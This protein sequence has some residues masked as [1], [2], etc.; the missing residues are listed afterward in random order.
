M[1][2][3]TKI[4]HPLLRSPGTSQRK[5][6]A[7]AQSL[8]PELAAVDGRKLGD[9]LDFVHRYARQVVFHQYKTNAEGQ[10]YVEL[11]N[12]LGFFEK[13]LP[14]TLNQF[15]RT[16]FNQLEADLQ[17]ILEGLEQKPDAASLRLLL[18]FCYFDLIMPFDHLQKAVRE[19]GFEQLMALLD[20]IVR[21]SLLPLLRHFIEISKTS[22]QY[23]RT[24][25]YDFLG[26]T[27]TPWDI[28]I[29]ELFEWS[30]AVLG[31]QDGV[32]MSLGCKLGEIM[33][34]WLVEQRGIADKLPGFLYPSISFL[35]QRHE[36]HLGLLYAFLRLFEHF[37]GNL[38]GLT[39]QH[40]EFFYNDV[41]RLK[42]RDM[43]P[44]QAHLVFE[45]SKHLTSHLIGEGTLFK[46]AKDGKNVDILFGLDEEIVIDKAKVVALKT[47]FL[48]SS[49][50]YTKNAAGE[51]TSQSVVE[52]VY[53]APVANSADGNGKPFQEKQSKNWP[54][55]GA[56]VSK[57]TPESQSEPANYPLGRLG[58][59]LASPVLWLNEGRR[60]VTITI[61]CNVSEYEK[62]FNSCSI[63]ELGEFE[64][65]T[66]YR[67]TGETIKSVED[68]FIEDRNVLQEEFANR[69][70]VEFFTEGEEEPS[71]NDFLN[72]ISPKNR[73]LLEALA[74]QDKKGVYILKEFPFSSLLQQLNLLK[75]KDLIGF[76]PADFF[77]TT[78]WTTGRSL[79][80]EVLDSNILGF[81]EKT[82]VFR[83]DIS[84]FLTLRFSG[85]K[86]WLSPNSQS[87]ALISKSKKPGGNVILRIGAILDAEKPKV[88]FYNEKELKETFRTQYPMVQIVL[89]QEPPL[90]CE[91]SSAK[92]VCC[93]EANDKPE[94]VSV[95]LYHFFRFLKVVK[96]TIDVK[97][98]GIK[99]LVVQNEESL[100]DVN[101]LIY[102]FGTRPKL[103][104]EF[105]VG[106]KELLCK[107]WKEFSLNVEW[108]EKPADFKKHY[109]NYGKDIDLEIEP[110]SEKPLEN[111]SFL[112]DRDILEEGE[113]LDYG[114]G[115]ALFPN[116]QRLRY[117]YSFSRRELPNFSFKVFDDAEL[118]SLTVKSR[119]AFA[120]LRLRGA[121]FQHSVYA[122]ALGRYLMQLAKIP[123]ASSV[124]DI[125]LALG[126]V[127]NLHDNV[128]DEIELVED[129]IKAV[130]EGSANAEALLV[131]AK[132]LLADLYA[133]N[134]DDDD[135]NDGK[136]TELLTVINSI[137]LLEGDLPKEPYTPKIKSIHIDY[138]AC[139]EKVDLIHLYPF[140]R[141]SKLEELSYSPTL[142]PCFIDEGTLFIGLEG[143]RKRSNLN[144]LFQF[145]EATADSE[146]ERAD[147]HWHYLTGNQWKPLRTGFEILSDKTEKMTR[148]GIVKIAVP[149]DI[150]NEGNTVMPPVE[151]K[152]LF[153]LK[154]SAPR[155]AG[156]VAELVGVHAQ[157]ALATYKPLD[158]SDLGR[159][160]KLL[161]PMQVS[162][163]LQP[164]FG[165]KKIEQ[166]YKSFGGRVAETRGTI[167]I[168]MS[169]LL[170]HKGRSVDAFDIEHLVLDAFPELFKC[171]CI[172]HTM[173]LSAKQYQR[174]LEVAPG[175]LI[176]AVIPDLTKLEP[177]DM[178]EPMAPV[179]TLTK[180]EKFLKKRISPFARIR[181]VN[182]RYEKVHVQVNARL[183]PGRDESYYT[184][185]LK[186][187][188]CHFLAPW[189][190]GDSD[191]LSFGQSLAYSD[192]V[193]FIEG[194]GYIDHVADLRL[195]NSRCPPENG[196]DIGL[197]EIVPLTARSIL[198]CAPRNIRVTVDKKDCPEMRVK[199]T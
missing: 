7:V 1:T 4:Q 13:S 56:K 71:W 128:K 41:L 192:I 143:V 178:L 49:Q 142:L 66:K 93:L 181:V 120:R 171:K 139:S 52:G 15:A 102:P 194:L 6:I 168:R 30:A 99:N 109:E 21:T 133:G 189:Y 79:L 180:V 191:K 84:K 170:R 136:L 98:S 62:L 163:T 134:P 24:A 141:S 105:Y 172:S 162:K 155:A 94:S 182:P 130:I 64:E 20:R 61:E 137:K 151:D 74:V 78:S 150:S 199:Q 51:N 73:I 68:I 152:H 81:F 80:P 72:K 2:V 70:P 129:K 177:G 154:V 85:D 25:R 5:R 95:G 165:I 86:N 127:K 111:K 115:E 176:V 156:S 100:Q 55:L 193:G 31:R 82:N 3:P 159:V 10:G 36:P 186:T 22:A 87:A 37:Q 97:V 33:Q 69:S 140:E 174:D 54:S 126:E 47:L 50:A 76:N 32:A 185:Q 112:V 183:R 27:Q 119:D 117:G 157:A 29:E 9:M 63:Q 59:I 164:D 173:W 96:T 89:N 179:S 11:N 197:K 90:F 91:N 153:W 110:P 132:K 121:S 14:F 145:A 160:A 169:E 65:V 167:P 124:N 92:T 144:L 146:S 34:H 48:N 26:F 28:P 67:I 18:D 39:Q 58:F 188:L 122:F 123:D 108:K 43:L 103:Y 19:F 57:Y 35:E 101:S 42:R 114:R 131:E 53:I 138:T 107:H 196:K 158:G 166:P 17:L 38:N 44:D 104:S 16:D 45:P 135:E 187:D 75:G 149:E 40:L 198:A 77:R 118:G 175:F 88:T 147:I 12:W 190:L 23:F 46:D 106:S 184:A 116:P 83:L 125:N 161:E 8:R 148:S 195:F 113:W 60:E